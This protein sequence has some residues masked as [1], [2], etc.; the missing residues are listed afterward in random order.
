MS[1]F[2]SKK[3]AGAPFRAPALV[4]MSS[5]FSKIKS[6][7]L[8]LGRH[9]FLPGLVILLVFNLLNL[10]Q[11]LRWD[12][13]I[14]QLILNGTLWLALSFGNGWLVKK[15]DRRHP[16]L[17]APV[18]RLVLSFLV[19]IAYSLAVAVPV[20]VAYAWA[21]Y[22]VPPRTSLNDID[23]GFLLSVIVITLLVSFFLH[24]RGFFLEWRKS[25]VEAERYKRAHLSAQYEA[26]RNQ[27]NPHFLF[28]S[29]NVL[30]S[31]VYKDQDLAARFIKQLSRV[32]RYVLDTREREVVTLQEER[33][34]LQAYVFLLKMRFGENL[35]VDISVPPDTERYLAPLSLQMLVENA[36]KH[37]VISRQSPLRI[38]VRS[39]ADGYLVVENN[40]Q[41]KN[42]K[43][44]SLGVGLANIKDRYAMVSD[45]AVLV[46]SDEAAGF[47]RVRLPILTMETEER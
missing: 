10:G 16:W 5:V 25:I 35:Q 28:N 29:L 30:S 31:L 26:L 38:R 47:F 46:E 4:L 40:W 27:V 22:D 9:F 23:R 2:S 20:F 12:K 43:A 33:D 13:Q 19:T 34:M 7:L 15:L 21:Y 45:R 41:P 18:K 36:T 24:G 17:E 1:N 11:E 3:S 39:E 8:F 42:N 14:A 32:Y 44:E 37:N 6:V